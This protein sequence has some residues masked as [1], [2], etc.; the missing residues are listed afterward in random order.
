M[1]QKNNKNMD[2]IQINFNDMKLKLRNNEIRIIFN[3]YQ[4]YTLL[5]KSK[6]LIGNRYLLVI[7]LGILQSF[8]FQLLLMLVL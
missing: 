1:I 5:L 3:G 7:K 4:D 2:K 6:L 8:W